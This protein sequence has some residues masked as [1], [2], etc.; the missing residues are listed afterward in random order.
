MDEIVLMILAVPFALALFAASLA[1]AHYGHGI[2]IWNLDSNL[3]KLPD[4][5]SC[6]VKILFV[7]YIAYSTATTFT[8]CSII[9]SYLR[10]FPDKNLRRVMFMVGFV[11]ISF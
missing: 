4:E 8:K 7:C 3:L 11:V 10:I 1:A 5:A 2:H 6:L 9:A